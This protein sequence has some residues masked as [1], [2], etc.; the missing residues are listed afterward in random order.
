MDNNEKQDILNNLQL[1][2]NMYH[3]FFNLGQPYFTE[4]IERC[5]ISFDPLNNNFKLL[6]N[7]KFWNTLDLNQ[8]TFYIAHECLHVMLNHITR[9]IYM[10][11]N[12]MSKSTMHVAN[13]AMDLTINESLVKYYNFVR[14]EIDPNTELCWLK[15][16]FPNDPDLQPNHNFEY[17][18]E[19]LNNKLDGQSSDGST[20]T[21]QALPS[22]ADDHAQ[23]EQTD[24]SDKLVDDIL[25]NMSVQELELLNKIQKDVSEETGL[26]AGDCSGKISQYLQNKKIRKKKKWETIIHRWVNN[27]LK[28]TEHQNQQ[29]VKLNR[30]FTTL[31]KSLILPTDDEFIKIK[32]EKIDVAFYIDTSPS[33]RNY[34]QRFFNAAKSVPLDRFNVRFF[35]FST[36][37]E[38]IDL[39]DARLPSGYGTSFSI[40]ET[41]VL[42][43]FKKYPGAVFIVTDGYGN[44]VNPKMPARWYWFL[45][46]PY[47]RYIDVKSKKFVLTNFE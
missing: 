17:Y 36:Y 13:I 27:K 28:E 34:T 2:G 12:G 14:Q 37:V 8:K 30:R 43:E 24:A 1:Y 44:A 22:L 21:D 38:E 35:G 45:T 42:K 20:S 3:T 6:L 41:S 31:D 47:Y 9:Y 26:N 25:D 29:W 33:C 40:I 32:P 7:E 39:K 15:N 23:W 19:M 11:N 18:F 5:A 10:V 4:E 46:E 16:V